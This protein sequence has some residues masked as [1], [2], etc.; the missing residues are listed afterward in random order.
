MQYCLAQFKMRLD[1]DCEQRPP[2]GATVP[3]HVGCN[4]SAVPHIPLLSTSAHVY[5]C[6]VPYY[7]RLWQFMPFAVFM[8]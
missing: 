7:L 1:E 3:E 5:L 8:L 2:K 6:A 4:L